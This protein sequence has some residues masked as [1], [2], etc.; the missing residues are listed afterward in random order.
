MATELELI[1]NKLRPEHLARNEYDPN[2]L[3]SSGHKNALS[4]GDE[5]GKGENEGKIGGLTDINTRKDNMGRNAYTD[6]NGYGVTNPNA[7]SDGD[8]KGKG[9]LNDGGTIGGATDINIRTDNTGRN[10]FG[11]NKQYPD[12]AI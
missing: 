4:S 2:D 6:L 5:P 3:Y 8:E 11:E 7:I 10:K 9:Q 1:A 12:F